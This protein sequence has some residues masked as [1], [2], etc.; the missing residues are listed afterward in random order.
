MAAV[1][2]RPLDS[3]E[4]A[5][6][7]NGATE[8]AWPGFHEPVPQC[9]LPREGR[10]SISANAGGTWPE[11]RLGRDATAIEFRI[12]DPTRDEPAPAARQNSQI[13]AQW[14]RVTEQ[15]DRRVETP[16]LIAASSPQVGFIDSGEGAN[17]RAAPNGNVVAKLAPGAR[18]VV[19]GTHRTNSEW[20]YVTAAVMDPNS[21]SVTLVQGY[22]KTRLIAT[23]APEPGAVLYQVAAGD[24]AESVVRKYYAGPKQ[25]GFDLR[26]F[27]NVLQYVNSDK[28]PQ[29][30][31]GAGRNMQLVAGQRIWLVSPGY[32]ARLEGF[33]PSGSYTGGKFAQA[34]AAY[35][36]TKSRLRDVLDTM[37]VS[38]EVAG[39]YWEFLNDNKVA[40]AGTLAAVVALDW[41]SWKLA[42][43]PLIGWGQVVA[44]GI[45]GLLF[46]AGAAGAAVYTA[47]AVTHGTAW[48]DL[49]WH[50]ER[51]PK[52]MKDAS[53]QYTHMLVKTFLALG[54]LVQVGISLKLLPA[55]TFKSALFLR[56][57]ANPLERVAIDP[58]P[59]DLIV[60]AGS[61]AAERASGNSEVSPSGAAQPAVTPIARPP[62]GLVPRPRNL[63]FGFQWLAPF[64]RPGS[65]VGSG[66]TN[67]A[68][69]EGGFEPEELTEP[70]LTALVQ[71][72]YPALL[73][74]F[75]GL[76]GIRSDFERGGRLIDGLIKVV[77]EVDI[78]SEDLF[79]LLKG[80][81]EAKI[82]AQPIVTVAPGE[83]AALPKPFPHIADRN[84]IVVTHSAPAVVKGGKAAGGVGTALY[85]ALMG[86]GAVWIAPGGKTKDDASQ[87][88]HG[89]AGSKAVPI[90]WFDFLKSMFD[91][92]NEFVNGGMWTAHHSTP[93]A[94]VFTQSNWQSYLEAS[95]FFAERI[96]NVVNVNENAL[97]W[98]NDF[99]LVKVGEVLEK[100]FLK[101]RKALT[102][103]KVFT[104]HIPF[105]PPEV[106]A[107]VPWWKE[108]M[109]AYLCYDLITF[110]LPDRDV[111]NFLETIYKLDAET[112]SKLGAKRVDGGTDYNRV[113]VEYTHEDGTRRVMELR[114]VPIGINPDGFTK[115]PQV[116]EP[117]KAL[118]EYKAAH[119]GTIYIGGVER[120]DTIKNLLG[121]VEAHERFLE[122]HPEFV[123]K[124][125][126]IQIAVPS[127]QDVPAYREQAIALNGLV[128]R[129][130]YKFGTATYK[131][132]V[133]LQEA[134]SQEELLYFYLLFDILFVAS[135]YD[136]MNLVAPEY[137]ATP[138]PVNDPGRVVLSTG[139]GVAQILKDAVL[140]N[141]FSLDDMARAVKAAID[142][143]LD[144]RRVRQER[145]L[146][147]VKAT[148]SKVWADTILSAALDLCRR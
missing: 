142:M 129:I 144:E 56:G 35:A 52:A 19:I 140:T 109:R 87:L 64:L 107:A 69:A 136:G 143:P 102:F 139:A 112:G 119:P 6:R 79:Q 105:P 141:P 99:Q 93:E 20:Q 65:V 16:T 84:L 148:T 97:L 60:K 7:G 25:P 130:N 81:W 77:R 10:P 100:I 111:K 75:G 118:A 114:A 88:T 63:P 131:P 53:Q 66:A 32:A 132:I 2:Q 37:E 57:Q 108:I 123:G 54:S 30:V 146:E 26:F 103:K 43:S 83:W 5:P 3:P 11:D 23:D 27:E 29:G 73:A 76:Q 98:V 13:A 47:D 115:P 90:V 40:I 94:G 85:D 33:V 45:Q 12:P 70:E 50:S 124:V 46:L 101:L 39:E 147:C 135:T 110:H 4:S 21:A 31:H 126:L 72:R 49:A 34:K 96:L 68:T 41:W 78:S 15:L 24:T 28:R 82:S 128:D 71:S 36:D 80:F 89:F 127:R 61:S 58:R 120:N 44:L 92:Y 145:N 17:V 125:V 62:A 18:V 9:T 116:S 38:R 51:N 1:R 138:R 117:A 104:L 95:T 42:E 133:L 8:H 67:L 134:F 113:S 121:K 137:I 48:L 91:G 74:H 106:F 86:K 14:A 55:F 122:M 22:V 59:D